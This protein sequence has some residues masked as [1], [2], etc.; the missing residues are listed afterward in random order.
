[1]SCLSPKLVSNLHFLLFFWVIKSISLVALILSRQSS[2]IHRVSVSQSVV[3]QW[4]GNLSKF[5]EKRV[6]KN[7]KENGSKAGRKRG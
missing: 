7:E 3:A 6:E 2:K 4:S 1:M 5:S